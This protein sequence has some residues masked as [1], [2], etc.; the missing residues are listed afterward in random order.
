MPEQQAHPRKRADAR[1]NVEAILEAAAV[2]LSEDADASL[3]DIAAAAGV[4]RVTLYAH[5]ASRRELVEATVTRALAEGDAALDAVD[6]TGDPRGALC[7]LVASSWLLIAQIGALTV[8]AESELSPDE[9]RRL[10]EQP[11]SRVEGLI[12]RGQSEGV[13]RSDLPAPWLV[14]LLHV[15]MHGIAGEIR[16][17]RI[18]DADAAFVIAST[19][20]AAYT[21]PG[22]PVLAA[23]T[24]LRS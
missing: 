7:R 19:A 17:G 24:W 5:F 16:A 6:L 20:L 4:G 1:R 14:T 9:L 3:A 23:E 8:A 22:E 2:R 15:I 12:V 13:F 10:H 11:A 21:P 18:A